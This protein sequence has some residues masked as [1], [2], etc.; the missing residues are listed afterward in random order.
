MSKF[1]NEMVIAQDKD[2]YQSDEKEA[3]KNAKSL[4]CEKVIHVT[5]R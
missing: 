3:E 5:K 2:F 4:D 1:F